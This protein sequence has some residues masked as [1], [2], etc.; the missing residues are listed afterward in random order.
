MMRKNQFG[1][2]VAPT[3]GAEQPADK[4]DLREKR[5]AFGGLGFFFLDQAGED[6]GFARFDG[7]GAFCG[8]FLDGWGVDAGGGGG[9]G[10]ADLLIDFHGDLSARID[11]R[12]TDSM[13]PV[14]VYWMQLMMPVDV[15]VLAQSAL[16]DGGTRSPP[17]SWPSGCLHGDMRRGND[18]SLE[19]VARALRT[20]PKP[21][22]L[23]TR[24]RKTGHER[25]DPP[26]PV[27]SLP[28]MRAPLLKYHPPIF[29]FILEGDFGDGDLDQNLAHRDIELGIAEFDAL[30]VGGLARSA[31]RCCPCRDDAHIRGK[32]HYLRP[33]ATLVAE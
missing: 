25:S 2:V 21:A 1:A 8:T 26:R 6:D 5:Q 13:T 33:A 18:L 17:E 23:L 3:L 28:L 11:A 10:V 32:P 24:N 31:G 16:A 9:G 19:S 20:A 29:E 30:V 14:S 15:V 22:A 7:D 27:S 4:G 12:V